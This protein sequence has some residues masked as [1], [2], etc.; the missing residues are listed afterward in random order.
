MSGE[1][2]GALTCQRGPRPPGPPPVSCSP[3]P[4]PLAASCTPEGPAPTHSCCL[5]REDP[6]FP[7]PAMFP[8]HPTPLSS[9]DL[10]LRPPVASLPARS[11]VRGHRLCAHLPVHRCGAGASPGGG[12]APWGWPPGVGREEGGRSGQR[13][14][15]SLP[16]RVSPEDGPRGPHPAVPSQPR[17]EAPAAGGAQSRH[18]EARPPRHLLPQ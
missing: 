18:A 1:A 8:P 13:T 17:R 14:H 6:H 12:A 9:P 4:Q 10:P 11:E 16:R 7:D 3:F 5:V 2:R 15:P